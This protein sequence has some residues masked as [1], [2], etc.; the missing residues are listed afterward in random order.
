MKN[1]FI[2]G[3]W[4]SNKTMTEAA[5]WLEIFS[6]NMPQIPGHVSII[7]CPGFIHLPLFSSRTAPFALGVQ[8]VSAYETGA[9]TGEIAASMVANTVSYAMIGHSERRKHLGETDEVVAEKVKRVLSVGIRPVVCVSDVAQ[10]EKL[11]A[12]VPEFTKTGLILY[13][14]LFA[15]GSG[16]SD[17]PENANIAAGSIHGILPETPILYGGSVTAENVRGFVGTE[18]ITGVGVGGASLDAAKF[19]SLISAAL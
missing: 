16:K 3:N 15:I 9:F 19:L 8:N 17:S 11:A 5:N 6:K 13:E 1:L 14:P 18:H 10:A 4:K 7:V 12:S 2:L